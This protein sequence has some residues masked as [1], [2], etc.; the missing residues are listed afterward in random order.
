MQA[1]LTPLFYLLPS[2]RKERQRPG[3]VARVFVF[4]LLRNVSA[5]SQLMVTT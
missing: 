1:H 2:I 5:T 3:C 4:A